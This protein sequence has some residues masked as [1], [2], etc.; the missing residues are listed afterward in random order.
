MFLHNIYSFL[1]LGSFINGDS[2]CQF[3]VLDSSTPPLFFL[4]GL[5]S[6]HGL[7]HKPF[8]LHPFRAQMLGHVIPDGIR[9]NENT[10]L[11]SFKFFCSFKNPIQSCTRGTTTQQAFFLHQA[12][13]E[14]EGL[15]VA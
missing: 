13:G 12:T 15:L 6:N 4:L 2:S 14:D 3:E 1:N 10:F 11:S 5:L 8:L 7:V 9:A